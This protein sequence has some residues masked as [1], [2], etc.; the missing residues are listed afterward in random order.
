[1]T[2]KQKKSS[3]TSIKRLNDPLGITSPPVI[4]CSS[5]GLTLFFILDDIL[6]R[7]LYLAQQAKIPDRHLGIIQKQTMCC[8]CVTTVIVVIVF[9]FCTV[10]EVKYEKIKPQFDTLG[11]N[12]CT[13]LRFTV[14]ASSDYFTRSLI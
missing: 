9:F 11:I 5:K 3:S 1:M 10:S 2:G 8:C 14:P 12:E 7:N 13:E 6:K 4:M